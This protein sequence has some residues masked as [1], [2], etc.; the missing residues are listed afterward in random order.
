MDEANQPSHIPFG[1]S[2]PGEQENKHIAN[3][4]HCNIIPMPLQIN[5]SSRQ[6]KGV[7]P[8]QT[9]LADTSSWTIIKD[10]R[11]HS[12]EEDRE[13]QPQIPSWD[14]RQ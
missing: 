2:R 5:K 1:Y 3:Q 11:I 4:V 6:S 7:V 8:Q 12:L 13:L 10:I 14:Y 9:V